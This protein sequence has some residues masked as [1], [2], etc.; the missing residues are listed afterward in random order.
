MARRSD[1]Y[2][3]T[4]AD[5]MVELEKQREYMRVNGD[6]RAKYTIKYK[7]YG[8]ERTEDVWALSQSEAIN[9]LKKDW[10]MNGIYIEIVA[11]A[12]TEKSEAEKRAEAKE[13][14]DDGAGVQ[15]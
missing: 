10:S 12:Q 9:Q 2:I 15:N 1:D 5:R 7:I 4:Y 3:P 11:V 8:N 6:P 13:N 14:A